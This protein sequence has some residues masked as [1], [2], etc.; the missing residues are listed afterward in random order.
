MKELVQYKFKFKP[1]KGKNKGASHGHEKSHIFN[2]RQDQQMVEAFGFD[3][4]VKV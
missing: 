3:I 4:G 2:K 1:D